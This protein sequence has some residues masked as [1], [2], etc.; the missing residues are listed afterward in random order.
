MQAPHLPACE[1]ALRN[2]H[3]GS[4]VSLKTINIRKIVL[5]T[6]SGI[7][8]SCYCYY[9]NYDYYYHQSPEPGKLWGP[10]CIKESQMFEGAHS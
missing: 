7:I 1:G 10:G 3:S 8:H 4:E 2:P 6:V 9:I 5:T